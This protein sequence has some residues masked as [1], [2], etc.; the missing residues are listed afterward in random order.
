MRFLPPAFAVHTS[1]AAL[2]GRYDAFILDQFG[3]LHNGKDALPGAVDCVR[4]LARER[5]LPL[6]ILSNTSSPARTTLARLPGLGFD[7]ADFV[8]AVTS[9]EEAAR[10]V[11]E[12]YG[13]APGPAK[14][15]VWFTWPLG[16]T[17]APDPLR[18]L[19]DCGNVRPTLDVSRASFVV[20]HGSG[21]IRGAA[22]DGDGAEE[23]ATRSMGS[24]LDDGDLTAVDAVLRACRARELPL[25]CANPD[26]VVLY[27][28]GG[29][30]HMPG[31]I[32][33]RYE[34]LGGDVTWFGKPEA[35]HFAACLR[36]LGLDRARVAHVGDSL[37]HD[38]AGARAAGIDSVFVVGGIH[39]EELLG[40]APGGGE[41]QGKALPDEAELEAFF[42]REGCE[43]THVVPMFRL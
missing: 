39:G 43:P 9:G 37:R 41:G 27:H 22:V 15:F 10:L 17:N 11:A 8:G 40:G 7:P 26:R 31:K 42:R 12:R 23:P 32:A 13:A 34:E 33:A 1:F 29:F 24:F 3:V 36:E 16:H 38:V 5:N 35:S 20:A 21:C 6:I 30:K 4:Y 2:A 28:A 18:F 14:E 19:E 25:V